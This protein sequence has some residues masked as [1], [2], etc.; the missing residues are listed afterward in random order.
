MVRFLLDVLKQSEIKFDEL[1]GPCDF[2]EQFINGEIDRDQLQSQADQYWDRLQR[3][4]QLS[5]FNTPEI[6]V[7]RIAIC[8]LNRC[9][10]DT[11]EDLHWI[12]ELLGMVDS[13]ND[14]KFLELAKA[15]SNKSE[16]LCVLAASEGFEPQE[17]A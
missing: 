11:D 15:L 1:K 7:D 4:D 13:R 10:D 16:V 5:L 9:S 17:G 8:L 14:S 3:E 6:L 2:A 12:F